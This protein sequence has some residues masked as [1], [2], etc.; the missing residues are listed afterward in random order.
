MRRLGECLG[1]YA[2]G[3]LWMQ[4]M[5]VQC[6]CVNGYRGEFCDIQPERNG[7][8]SESQSVACNSQPFEFA[9]SSGATIQVDFAAYGYIN[10]EAR[11]MCGSAP[12]IN[13]V[14]QESCIALASL[15]TLKNRCQGLTFC[16][17][18]SISSLFP[19]SPCPAM[20]PTSLLYRMRCSIGLL[21]ILIAQ[22]CYMFIIRIQS[23][24]IPISAISNRNLCKNKSINI[25]RV[26]LD[27][28]FHQCFFSLFRLSNPLF[29][30]AI[31]NYSRTFAQ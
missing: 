15:Q 12:T 3:M 18:D 17:I 7:T 30:S 6:L 14:Q 31:A 23:N 16:K 28:R 10:T 4:L 1:M 5:N 24:Q 22:I 13:G 20:M 8:R 26:M 29:H 2:M 27:S 9:C 11:Q 19:D 25:W 21:N